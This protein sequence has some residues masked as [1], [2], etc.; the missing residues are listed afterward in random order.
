MAER[1]RIV[2]NGPPPQIQKYAFLVPWTKPSK[3]EVPRQIKIELVHVK[4]SGA[5]MAL[6]C[7]TRGEARKVCNQ[8]RLDYFWSGGGVEFIDCKELFGPTTPVCESRSSLADLVDIG[9]DG[10]TLPESASAGGWVEGGP[11]GARCPTCHD[12]A[13]WFDWW[14]AGA[15]GDPASFVVWCDKHRNITHLLTEDGLADLVT[16]RRVLDSRLWAAGVVGAQYGSVYAIDVLGVMN[17]IYVGQS[18]HPPVVRWKQHL[19]GV[20]TAKVFKHP[21]KSVGRLREDLPPQP[22]ISRQRV[23][24]AAERWTAAVFERDGYVV[25]GDGAK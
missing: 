21:D 24:L 17:G 5:S 11:L 7:S 16:A 9:P 8:N 13:R 12:P 15:H 4:D 6:P 19:D 18:I 14:T 10:C 3:I 23:A 22:T 25:Y 1:M 20:H 2:S